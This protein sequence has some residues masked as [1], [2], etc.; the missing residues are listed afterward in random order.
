MADK[1]TIYTHYF[2]ELKK[3]LK[4]IQEYK[5]YNDFFN[6]P[7]MQIYVKRYNALLKKYYNSSGIPLEIVTIYDH[8]YSSTGKTVN[9]NCI[10]KM[11][12]TIQSTMD[13]LNGM[14]ENERN[15]V[16][17]D[18]IPKHQIR[19]CLKT[20]VNGC[21]KNPILEKNKV[22]IGMPFR[23]EYVN[24]FEFGLKPALEKSEKVCFRADDKIE[25]RDVMCKICEEMQKSNYLIFNISDHNP[26]VML[27]LGLSYGLGK[28][29][30]IIKDKKTRNISDLSN[31]EYI[32]YVHA[33]DLRDKIIRYF[34][35]RS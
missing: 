22:F 28:E 3:L 20:G 15:L 5:T 8:E 1:L 7:A 21:P 18:N 31:T 27:E 29:T 25:N 34:K 32:E 35:D 9:N 23:D 24:D 4:E 11:T 13:L 19:R 16:K 30:I 2:E 12:L 14:I 10:N 33:I 26:N 6:T 17:P